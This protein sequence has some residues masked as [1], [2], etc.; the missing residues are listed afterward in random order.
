MLVL[1]RHKGQAVFIGKNQE[2]RIVVLDQAGSVV[3]LGIDAPQDIPIVRDN[4]KKR[5]RDQTTEQ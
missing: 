2:I 3:R 5:N 1:T 4:A